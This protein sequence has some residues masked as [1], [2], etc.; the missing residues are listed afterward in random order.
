MSEQRRTVTLAIDTNTDA[1]VA[2]AWEVLGRIA[3]G[4]TCDGIECRIYSFTPDED[5]EQ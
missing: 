2:R 5:D 4:L 3:G 1:E